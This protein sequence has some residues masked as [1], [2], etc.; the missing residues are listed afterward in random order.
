METSLQASICQVKFKDGL[1]NLSAIQNSI[2][3][4]SDFFS[5]DVSVSEEYIVVTFRFHNEIDMGV[6]REF[7]NYVLGVMQNSR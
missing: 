4:F 5:A 3:E 2:E 1:Y 6:V 7:C